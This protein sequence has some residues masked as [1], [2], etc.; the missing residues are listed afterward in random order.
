MNT[1]YI[2][3]GGDFDGF[4]DLIDEDDFVIGAD[5]GY[6]YLKSL[7][8][9]P[10]LIIGDFDSS[11][12]PDFKEKIKLNPEKDMTDTYAAIEEGIKKGY[13]NFIVYGGLGGRLSHSLA[14][15]KIA[16]DFK[17]RGVDICFKSKYQK[18]FLVK[19]SF[20]QK[21][22]EDKDYYVSVFSLVDTSYGLSI[23]GLKYELS[24]FDLKM[25]DHLGVSNETVGSDF[26]IALKDGLLLVV[27]EDKSL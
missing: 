17:K 13:K 16:Q 11:K 23:K 27:Y 26:E 7:E 6:D 22:T 12:E 10:N 5:K 8:I 3:G 20:Q 14:N 18:V 15:I 9:N 24:D 21:F 19:D 4:F 25:E 2:F 1:C